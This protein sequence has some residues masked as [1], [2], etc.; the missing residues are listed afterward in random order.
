MQSLVAL[1]L[2]TQ[3]VASPKLLLLFI[4]I[5][6]ALGWKEKGHCL[7][8]QLVMERLD[9]VFASHFQEYGFL[10]SFRAIR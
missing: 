4:G 5:K 1:A 9:Y 6:I 10:R 3:Q 7:P 8:T 2:C